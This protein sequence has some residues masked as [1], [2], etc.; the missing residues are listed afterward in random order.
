MFCDS[1]NNYVVA[2]EI[3]QTVNMYTFFLAQKIA[4][5]ERNDNI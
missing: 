5:F 2:K 1:F 3:L 4:C